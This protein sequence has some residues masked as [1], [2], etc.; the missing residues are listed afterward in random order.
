[1]T[2]E[3]VGRGSCGSSVGVIGIGSVEAAWTDE[4]FPK[5]G[6]ETGA[7]LGPPEDFP[8]WDA[9]TDVSSVV[10]CK[11]QRGDRVPLTVA[12]WVHPRA[13]QSVVSGDLPVIVVEA[14]ADPPEPD[15][16]L[17]VITVAGFAVSEIGI[18]CGSVPKSS[19]GRGL[20]GIPEI[21]LP[22]VAS[23]AETG[24]VATD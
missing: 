9:Q 8:V 24:M 4:L 2:F 17:L 18:P 21:E 10:C 13:D 5:W 19:V 12:N 1:M 23:G 11:T 15:A 20:V 6:E 16:G 7:T 22:K 14:P 3:D